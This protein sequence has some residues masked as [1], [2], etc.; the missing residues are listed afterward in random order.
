L[1]ERTA[2]RNRVTD[3]Q[4]KLGDIGAVAEAAVAETAVAEVGAGDVVAEP[5]GPVDEDRSQHSTGSDDQE[6]SAHIAAG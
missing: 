5:N 2:D 4:L 6:F 1:F 3:V